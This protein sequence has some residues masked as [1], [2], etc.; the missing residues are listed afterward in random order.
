MYPEV[1]R[2][3]G[4]VMQIVAGSAQARNDFITYVAEDIDYSHMPPRQNHATSHILP[5]TYFLSNFHS[6]TTEKYISRNMHPCMQVPRTE[7]TSQ[8]AIRP[9][10]HAT[11]H[12]QKSDNRVTKNGQGYSQSQA[13]PSG[14]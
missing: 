5:G 8:N 6:Q 14:D 4:G 1:G 3:R 9:A 13:K 12:H 10:V 7:Q 2:G 11:N